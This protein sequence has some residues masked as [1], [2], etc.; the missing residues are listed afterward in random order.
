[1]IARTVAAAFALLLVAADL[2]SAAEL[3]MFTRKGCPWCAK[4]E[5]EVGRIYPQTDE[6]RLAPLRRIDIDAPSTA[7]LKGVNFS[8]G[9]MGWLHFARR[10]DVWQ[11]RMMIPQLCEQVWEWF[12]EA[13]TLIPGGVLEEAGAEWVPPRRDMVNPAEEV[14][15][16]KDRMRLGLLTPD[17]ALREMGYTDPDEVLARFAT[18]LGK[19]DAAGLVFDYDARKVSAAGQQTVPPPT[20]TESTND[21][22]SDDQDA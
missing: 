12:V 16:I 22:G 9:R 5:A 14:E 3:L 10:V 11:W 4:F 8:S 2:A 21:D 6:G 15:V 20:T 7:D 13:Q 19:V 18:H 17:D 1:M